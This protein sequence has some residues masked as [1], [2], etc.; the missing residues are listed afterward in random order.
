MLK[1]A[2]LNQ[3]KLFKWIV[4]PIGLANALAV[5]MHIINNLFIDML[6]KR[7]GSSPE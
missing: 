2:F 7:S 4:I 6:E 3:H 5:F 1:T